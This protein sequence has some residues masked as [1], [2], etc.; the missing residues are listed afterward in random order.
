MVESSPAPAND[1]ATKHHHH[2]DHSLA[3]SSCTPFLRKDVPLP[4]GERWILLVASFLKSGLYGVYGPFIALW[5]HTKGFSTEQVGRLSACDL[6]VSVFAAP[7]YGVVLDKFRCHNF[8]LV[9]TMATVGVLKLLYVQGQNSFYALL[10]L[11]AF[12]APLLRGA[13]GAFDGQCLYALGGNLKEEFG[14]IKMFA[15]LGYGAFAVATGQLVHSGASTRPPSTSSSLNDTDQNNYAK[16][17]RVLY[18]F[19]G[20]SFVAAGF[21]LVFHRRVKSIKPDRW[22]VVTLTK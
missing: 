5:L 2:V 10:F 8:G 7:V 11:T 20:I 6:L 4:P 21:W 3:P 19:A 13:S 18:F 17:D 12:T 15:A 22:Y 9:V 16:I 14:K 1:L